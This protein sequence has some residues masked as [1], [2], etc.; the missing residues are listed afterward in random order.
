MERLVD[1]AVMIIAMIV[2][3][4]LAKRF[5]EF[6]VCSPVLTNSGRLLRPGRLWPV[7]LHDYSCVEF[8][9]AA[10]LWPFTA[11]ADLRLF[12]RLFDWVLA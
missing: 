2:P 5:S 12:D 4:L 7:Q 3:A 11:A 8:P 1:P 6:H 9:A 10:P